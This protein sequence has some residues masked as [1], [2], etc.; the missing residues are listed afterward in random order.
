MRRRH[1]LGTGLGAAL[2][3]LLAGCAAPAVV[4]DHLESGGVTS[5]E[6]SADD[7]E[8]VLSARFDTPLA[9]G[10]TVMVEWL[11]P[12]GSIYLRKP[13]RRSADSDYRIDTGIPVRGKAPGRRP[14]IWRVKL[15][16]D[17]R[18]LVSRAFEIRADGGAP[19]FASLAYCGPSRWND[20]VISAQPSA[21]AVRARP[22][23]W[24]GGKVLE[25]SGA[26]YSGAVLLTGCAP[27]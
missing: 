25:A 13:V 19:E 23:T 15:T 7:R 9:A 21:G 26:T 12:D 17:G 6:F 1:S 22:G 24:I 20:P 27:G 16:R 14:G 11:F 2:L 3:V 5:S 10:E 8:I 18:E 4:E